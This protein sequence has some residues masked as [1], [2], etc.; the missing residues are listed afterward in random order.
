MLLKN[1]TT[2][3]IIFFAI[4][5]LVYHSASQSLAQ[6]FRFEPAFTIGK[7]ESD[8]V[9]YLFA[10]PRAITT[11]HG[12]KRIYIADGSSNAIRVY[13]RRGRYRNSIGR[14][15]KGPGEF[16]NIQHLSLDDRDRLYVLDRLARRVTVYGA[17]ADEHQ[18][19]P[20]RARFTDPFALYPL[21]D[22]RHLILA[23]GHRA[24]DHRD[25]AYLFG[26]EFRRHTESFLPAIPT[27]F[28]RDTPFFLALSSNSRYRSTKF[29]DG[30]IALCHSSF[31]GKKQCFILKKNRNDPDCRA[32]E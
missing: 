30:Y 25:L 23:T 24:M 29:G 26:P 8:S 3:K 10:G 21:A 19:Y 7:A 14:R 22:D 13:D 32:V 18:S 17:E 31:S 27:L 5:F 20:I 12:G 11:S 6:S 1:S 15:G 2:A 9:Q 4:F 16:Q 28:E